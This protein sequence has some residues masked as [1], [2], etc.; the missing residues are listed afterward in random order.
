MKEGEEYK[1]EEPKEGIEGLDEKS[2]KLLKYGFEP[3]AG[4]FI[5]NN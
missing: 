4:P 1:E 3:K 5:Q 2:P